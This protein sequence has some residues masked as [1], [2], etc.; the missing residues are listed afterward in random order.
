MRRRGCRTDG[1]CGGGAHSGAWRSGRAG[2]IRWALVVGLVCTCATVGAECTMAAAERCPNEEFRT[3][4]S[5]RL[6]DCRAYELVTPEELGRTQAIIFTTSDHAIPSADG[7]H[8]VL[9]TYAPL[10]PNPSL[11]GTR[12]VFSRTAT[13]WTAK[14]IVAPG[15][16]APEIE[17]LSPDLS[18]VAFLSE[19]TLNQEERTRAP[20][21]Y[22]FGPVGGP[23]TLMAEAPLASGSAFSL[24]VGANAGTASVTA[25]TDV[26]LYSLDARLLPL[27]AERT[28]AE[29]A[30]PNFYTKAPNLYDWTGGALRLVNVEGAGADVK[31]LNPCGG[32]ELGAGTV[33]TGPG[34]AGAV[35]ADG[36][37]IFFTSPSLY[38]PCGPSRLYMRVDGRETVEI[39]APQ[40]VELNPSERVGVRYDAASAD[41]TYVVFNTATPLLAGETSSHNK[42]FIYDTMTGDLRLIANGV[43]TTDGTEGNRVLISE[44]GTTVY[45]EAS[46]SIYRYETQTGITS[47]VAVM[48]LTSE[49]SEPSYATPNGRFLVFVSGPEGVKVAGAH[50]LELEP[51]GV[52]HNELYRYDAATGSV[53]C[54][55]CGE[56]VT[57]TEGAMHE[58]AGHVLIT[59]DETPPFVQMSEDGQKVFFETT[60]RLVPQ[61]TNSTEETGYTPGMDVYEWEADGAQEGE[62]TD[63]FCRV[64]S[65]CTHLISTGEDVGKATFLGASDD[66]RNIFFATAAQ[67]IPKAT[68]EFPN[69][70]DAR[71][72]GG[73][74]PPKRETGCTSCQGVGSTAPLFS[75]GASGTFTGA[76]NAALFS[77]PTVV[78]HTT[79]T[80]KTVT[81]CGGAKSRKRTVGRCANTNIKGKKRTRRAGSRKGSRRS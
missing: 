54:V 71:V 35:S 22:Q 3:G 46:G 26:L 4:P 58:P 28:I 75:P 1:V 53:M 47:F 77:S 36:S 61:D 17:L 27:G 62:G 19:P 30:A 9:Q 59:S 32:G 16:A 29:E 65:G 45:Y 76:G 80:K 49:A 34:A 31:P 8:L 44:D 14:S 81:R 33:T 78:T 18:Q 52:G 42:L 51:R 60:A 79:M 20:T 70:Y 10:E 11:A 63:V 69:I 67:L 6:P 23:Y 56:G 5:A 38:S 25:F 2:F 74:A 43:P 73:F 57:P 41:G 37:K 15:A 21:T 68:P 24:M 39:S 64:A 50:G 7:E 66:G 48:S 13:G 72:D 40:G 12:A 55:S